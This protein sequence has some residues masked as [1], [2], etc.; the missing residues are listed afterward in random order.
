MA[1]GWSIFSKFLISDAPLRFRLIGFA[2]V[3]YSAGIS[4]AE[5]LGYHAGDYKAV[6]ARAIKYGR[7]MMKGKA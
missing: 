7:A 5:A 4:G 2:V 6:N 1:A 3:V